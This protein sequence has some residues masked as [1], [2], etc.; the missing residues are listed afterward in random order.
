MLTPVG[1]VADD[2]QFSD[3]VH[4]GLHPIFYCLLDCSVILDPVFKVPAILEEVLK[5]VPV[6]N[7]TLVRLL[8]AFVPSIH[9]IKLRAPTCQRRRDH[10]TFAPSLSYWGRGLGFRRRDLLFYR[11]VLDE[12]NAD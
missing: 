6:F 10:G 2:D 11:C 7:G 3:S 12:R 4:L 5:V 8:Q 9:Q 1:Q